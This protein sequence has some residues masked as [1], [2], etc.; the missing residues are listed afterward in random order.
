MTTDPVPRR[1]VVRRR[2]TGPQRATRPARV[3]RWPDERPAQN[4]DA[5]RALVHGQLRTGLAVV[6]LLAAFLGPL[7]LVFR[8]APQLGGNGRQLLVWAVLGVVIYPLF[9][10]LGRWYVRRAE[11]A[12]RRFSDAGARASDRSGTAG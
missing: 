4:P 11:L 5:V 6:G 12:E 3:L 7:P 8:A 9:V 10:L 2:P 1:D